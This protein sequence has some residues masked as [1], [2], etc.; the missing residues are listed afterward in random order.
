MSTPRDYDDVPGT[1]ILDSRSYRKGFSSM[2]CMSVNDADAA[3]N[4]RQMKT[5]ILPSFR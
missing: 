1:Y 5:P 4:S 2:F 3:L